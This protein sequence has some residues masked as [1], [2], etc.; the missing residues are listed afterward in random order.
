MALSVVILAAGKGTR[1][2]S[3]LPKVLHPVAGK[4][5]VQH[6]IDA[7][8]A[9]A[10]ESVT[11]VY[12]HGGD[13]VREAVSGELNWAQQ[14][15]Q[16][17]TGHAVL[18]AMPH[19]QGEVVLILYGDVP[20]TRPET[21]QRFVALADE[22]T[23][24][25]MTVTLNDPSGY[26]RIVRENGQVVRIVEQKDASEAELGICEINTGI[27]AVPRTFLNQVLPTLGNSNAQ[28]EYYLTDV[29]ALAVQAGLA[30][31]TAEP[32]FSWEVDGVNDRVQLARLERIYQQVQAEALMRAGVT[33]ADPS[34]LD[35]RGNI[36]VGRDLFI[37][38]NVLL[39]GEV[40][41]GN[42][43]RIG[44][45]C[46]IRNSRIADKVEI[47]PYTLI[48][49]AVIAEGAHLGPFARI[50][51]GTEIAADAKVGN[52]VETKNTRLGEGAKANHLSYLGDA[53]IGAHSNVGA[54]TIT[55]N[56]DGVNKSKTVIGEHAFIGSNSSLVAPLEIGDGA[57]VGA[58]SVITSKVNDNELAVA[59]GKQRN[60]ANWQRP[61]KRK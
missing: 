15:E 20:L 41:L 32:D 11:L 48:D 31:K 9:L 14:A 50:R 3:A 24:A 36:V 5:M 59:R 46:V 43:V 37:D 1:M 57:T 34:R 30:V 2:Q 61:V 8:A 17:G 7:A 42:Q 26:G 55:C 25:L 58:G 60:I 23:L 21:L 12:G 29:I 27:L 49:G 13:V 56:Y 52:F 19:T 22:N 45:G 47:E 40:S 53:D 44:A 10:P 51:P 4:A 54:G 18:Q 39:E 35:I 38:A 28:G 33:L 16:L 6:V